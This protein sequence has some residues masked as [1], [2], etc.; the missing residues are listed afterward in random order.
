MKYFGTRPTYQIFAG[1]TFITGC[2][3]FLFNKF[4]IR[5]HV[6]TDDDDIC[7]KKPA[8]D[9][10]SREMEQSKA[11]A[12]PDVAAKV[13]GK[14]ENADKAKV[15]CNQQTKLAPD[16]IDGGSDSGVDNPAYTDTDNSSERKDDSKSNG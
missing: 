1:A 9:V 3:Y 10:E 8:L 11:S 5:K 16:N 6:T 2:I 4:Y 13:E 14:P 7:K 15:E 12:P